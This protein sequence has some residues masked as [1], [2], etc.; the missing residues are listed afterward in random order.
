[1]N[2]YNKGD[3]ALTADSDALY[4][5]IG[6]IIGSIF[7]GVMEDCHWYAYADQILSTGPWIPVGISENGPGLFVPPGFDDAWLDDLLDALNAFVVGEDLEGWT[8]IPGVNDGFPVFRAAV[9]F[10]PNNGEASFE[11]EGMRG[12]AVSKPTPDPLKNGLE[13]DAWYLGDEEWDFSNIVKGTVTLVA[14]YTATVTVI[15]N[16]GEVFTYTVTVSGTVIESG[17]ITIVSGKA[18]ISGIPE[19]ANLEILADREATWTA[20]TILPRSPSTDF[21]YRADTSLEVTVTFPSPPDP[22]APV[23]PWTWIILALVGLVLVL[24]LFD[25]D[26]EDDD[27]EKKKSQ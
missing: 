17:T 23:I 18:V 15:A 22:P 3:I 10:D 11:T 24:A 2:C 26:D 5:D 20:P 7:S 21:R 12:T 4:T 14:K 13:F 19:G 9:R 6:G 16:D 8:I 27:R 25:D 1:M